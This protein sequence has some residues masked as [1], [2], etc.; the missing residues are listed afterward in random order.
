MGCEKMVVNNG[1][2]YKTKENHGSGNILTKN[3]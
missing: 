2:G 3:T 1:R